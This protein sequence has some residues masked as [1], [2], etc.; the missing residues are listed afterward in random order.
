MNGRRVS[1]TVVAVAMILS[2]AV[3]GCGQDSSSGSQVITP[4]PYLPGEYVPDV[5]SAEA[6]VVPY[7]EA[8]LSF[9]L[10]GRLNEILISEGDAV[11]VGQ[12]LA[13]LDTRDLDLSVRRA[14][15]A[16]KS[17]KAQL[18]KAE[19]GAREEEIALAEADVAIADGNL[20]SAEANLESAD[21]S[22][23][24]A[25]T[26]PTESDIQIAE[27][28]VELARS[29]LWGAQT[30]RDVIGDQLNAF[31][32]RATQVE[33]EA[34][35]AQVATFETQVT[36]AEL[37]LQETRAG[38]RD[39][40]VAIAK[41]Q[42]S[43]AEAGVQI[44][45]AQLEQAEAQLSLVNAGSRAEDLA[46]AEAAVAEAEVGLS[47]ARNALA[48]AI[49]K[50]PFSGTV[51]S[52]LLNE[53]ELVSPQVPVILLGDLS[54]LRVRTVDLSEADVNHVRLG[55]QATVTIDA[56]AGRELKGTVV[57]IAPVATER[58]GDRVYT[59]TL[60]LDVGPESGLR[61]GM[62]AFVEITVR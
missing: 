8:S 18:D 12:E 27:K 11:G 30:Q 48:D 22:L 14:E 41:A 7:K 62:T 45:E 53:G 29:Q 50:A 32:P 36:I 38:A 31:P 28:Q 15:A 5:I 23:Q 47:E 9:G 10:P 39:E 49:L 33:Y 20:A 3:S 16:S 46:V 21:A 60:D 43:Q 1:L 52:I 19:A 42:V 35:K 6:V 24:K 4:S 44:A 57:R 40:D 61:W 26:G 2:V 25:L 59:V 13:R 37:Q 54:R 17:M 55:Q 58:R 56:L 34:A 51:G